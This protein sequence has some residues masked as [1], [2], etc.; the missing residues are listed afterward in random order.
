MFRSAAQVSEIMRKVRS[1]D[2]QPEKSLRRALWKKGL[3][4]RVSP[5]KVLGKP[6]IVFPGPR[7][8][9]FVD[10]DFWHGNQWRNRGLDS[11]EQQFLNSP[12]AAYWVSKIQRNVDRDS[13]TTAELQATGWKVIRVWESQ[14]RR[15]V[16]EWATLISGEVQRRQMR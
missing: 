3:R 9:V 1:K 10:G 13:R 5:Q 4:F 6:D 15:G 8:A 2:T 12:N 7:V 14:L 11:L 16:E